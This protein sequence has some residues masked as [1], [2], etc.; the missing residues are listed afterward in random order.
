MSNFDPIQLYKEHFV[1]KQF[2]R[3][4]LFLPLNK[5]Y[6]IKSVLYPGS[7]VHMTPSFVFPKT[8][9]VDTDKRTPKFFADPRVV[10]F[11][12]AEKIYAQ[13]PEVSFLFTDYRKR[14]ELPIESFDLL[15]SQY[16]GI[17]SKYCKQFLKIN[18]LLLANNSHAD[19]TMAFL[20][21]D[22]EL[23]ATITHRNGKYKYS[24]EN[25]DL[26]FVPKKQE[27]PK[28]EEFEMNQKAIGYKKTVGNYLFRRVK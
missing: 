8:V 11:I 12:S 6:N 13:D 1:N 15:I 10:Q 4:N 23:I 24:S 9:Y 7:F 28:I 21:D 26:F 17:I 22:F 27:H 19:A 2:E 16:A 14:L 3:L 5:L 25:L 20:D 18:G